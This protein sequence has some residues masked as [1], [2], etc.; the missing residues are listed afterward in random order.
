M[1]QDGLHTTVEHLSHILFCEN[2]L[3]LNNDLITLDT[4]NLTGILINE[5][6]HPRFL[7]TTSQ[8]LSEM[9]LQVG[10]VD[11]HFF[12]QIEDFENILIILKT[13]STQ[14]RCHGQ[15]LLTVDVG[16]HHIIDVSSE[17]NP[18]ALER[19]DTGT[20][21]LRTISMKAGTKEHAR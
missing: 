2:L 20:V 17:L 1:N 21:E 7:D 18:R 4:D 19:N 16:V 11:L 9:L 5:V 10:L 12:G 13:D 15:L 3:A 14:K 6:F 8:L